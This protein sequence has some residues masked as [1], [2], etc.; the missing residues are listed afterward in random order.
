[1]LRERPDLRGRMHV[2][3]V[4][5]VDPEAVADLDA[6]PDGVT[7]H[8]QPP[9]SQRE[10]IEAYSRREI[11]RRYAAVLDGVRNRVEVPRPAAYE[12]WSGSLA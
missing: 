6:P 10:A 9:V 3:Q 11:A 4:G 7:V 1:A 5:A 2:W 8:R 12:V